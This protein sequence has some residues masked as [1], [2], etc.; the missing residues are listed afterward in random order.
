MITG[1]I[2]NNRRR[3]LAAFI[4]F[5][6]FFCGALFQETGNM[7]SSNLQSSNLQS[8]NLQYSSL[9]GS[10][11][12]KQE[13]KLK[14]LSDSVQ[15][16][17]ES[18]I[19]DT[20]KIGAYIFSVFDLDFPGNKINV[21][22][23]LWYNTKTDSVNMLEYLEVVNATEYNKTG[24]TSETRG[25]EGYQTV[26][27]NS[28]I[29]KVWDVTN[30]PFDHQTI[31]I[32][33]EDYD[34]DATR[35]I[36]VPDTASSKIDKNVRIDGWEIKEFGI[37]VYDHMYET[38]YGDP[39]VSADEFSKYSRA[40]IYFTLEREGKGLFFK[41]FVGLFI[42]VLIS[43]LTFFINPL[44]L[45]PRFG[46]SV[47][48]IFAAI[49]SQY[50]IT[51]TLP[52]NERLTLVDILHDISFIYIF[53]C[54]LVSTLSLHFMKQNKEDKSKKLDKY[55]LFIFGISYIVIVLYFV[56]SALK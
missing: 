32:R 17:V 7:Q 4:V 42:S 15:T 47:G 48:A 55:S 10:T 11:N 8:S 24:E 46:L 41:L 21:D 28:R 31:E 1:Y 9:Q 3:F 44:D 12:N 14:N 54:I 34:K 53:L 35:L 39:D 19:P 40:V 49:A 45:D 43:L 27:I 18:I 50:V 23:Y 56:I 20:V 13:T 26:R 30:F 22:F 2:R 37:K 38:N 5:A 36:M 16:D 25:T 29:K 6:V 33:I 52:Q 51:S